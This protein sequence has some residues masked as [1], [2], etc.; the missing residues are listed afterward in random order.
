MTDP[1]NIKYAFNVRKLCL[2]R[3]TKTTDQVSEMNFLSRYLVERKQT[4]R[5]QAREEDQ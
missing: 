4:H 3:I 5:K 2:L 1:R